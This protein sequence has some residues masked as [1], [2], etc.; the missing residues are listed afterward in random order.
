M[1][2][3][4]SEL[5]NIQNETIKKDHE[6]KFHSHNISLFDWDKTYK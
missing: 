3:I 1:I 5:S 2:E 4:S 6:G